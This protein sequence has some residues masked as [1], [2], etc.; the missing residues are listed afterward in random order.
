MRILGIDPG[1][2]ATGY[3]VV[4]L[5]GSELHRL[6]GG[7]IRCPR[8]TLAERLARIDREIGSESGHKSCF[9]ISR[10]GDVIVRLFKGR[11]A[12]M[13][14]W[15]VL[16]GFDNQPGSL[17]YVRINKKY[18]TTDKQ[19]F[20]GP[21]AN[22]IVGLLKSPGEIAFEWFKSPDY[23]KRQGL[24]GTGDFAS[25]AAECERWMNGLRV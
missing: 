25:K 20:R 7:V 5:K 9:V 1:S 8:G 16:I 19:S 2:R 3:G 24:F 21:E 13:A 6:E 11:Q 23:S 17:R 22:E 4:W 15:S 10:G 18:F 12:E 14:T